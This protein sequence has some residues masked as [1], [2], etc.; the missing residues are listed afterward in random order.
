MDGLGGGLTVKGPI[1]SAVGVARCPVGMAGRLAGAAAMSAVLV[2]GVVV[3]ATAVSCR[4]LATP[5]KI[6][7]GLSTVV[8]GMRSAPPVWQPAAKAVPN[9]NKDTVLIMTY[10]PHAISPILTRGIPT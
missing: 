9:N 7:S 5:P 6:G 1:R 2:A 10:H 3:A 8:A 4:G